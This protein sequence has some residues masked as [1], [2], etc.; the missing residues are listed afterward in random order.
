MNSY[1]MHWMLLHHVVGCIIWMVHAGLC[2]VITTYLCLHET[3]LIAEVS[4]NTAGLYFIRMVNY[5]AVTIRIYIYVTFSTA[6][7][8]D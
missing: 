6:Y 2:T 8:H 3:R 5:F 7:S 4:T 1:T